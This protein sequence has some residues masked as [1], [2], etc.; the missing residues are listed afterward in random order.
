MEEAMARADNMREGTR[1]RREGMK[2]IEIEEQCQSCGGTGL[3][4]GFAEHN[5]A[6]IVCHNCNGTG[7]HQYKHKYEEFKGRIARSGVNRVF[8]VN[9]GIGIGTG[10]GHALAEFGG[11]P[12]QEWE[13]GLPFP[14]GSE[15]REFTCPCWWYQGANYKLK[16]QW[17]ECYGS[18]GQSFSHC[19]HFRNK[20]KCWQRWD[21]EQKGGK[22]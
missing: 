3:Y 22:A 16:P 2:V 14:S 12:V 9:P 19:P 13:A 20:E 15:M 18:L 11:M 10:N 5:G 4:V 8:Q 21:D 17:K 6:A 7:C 1:E